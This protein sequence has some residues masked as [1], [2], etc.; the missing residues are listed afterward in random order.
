MDAFW[1]FISVFGWPLALVLLLLSF[2]ASFATKSTFKK[3]GAVANSRGFTGA[4]VAERILGSHQLSGKFGAGY[5]VKV[6]RASGM[7]TDHYSPREKVLRLSDGV[8][9]TASIAAAGVAAHECGHALQDADGF[10]PNK[11]RSAIAPVAGIG[12]KAGPYIAIA[13]VFLLY[14]MPNTPFGTILI[15]IGII[16]YFIAFVFYIVTLPV[17]FDASRRAIAVLREEGI[18]TENELDGARK[19]LR[20]AAMTYVVAALSSLLM[21][22][23]LMSMGRRRRS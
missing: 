4:E 7:L 9:A 18:L 14:Q 3:Y 16:A 19:V 8:Y 6:E 11:I 22:L 21:L 13:G 23:R 12:S 15:N 10:I 2:I 5:A 17:E 20:A 1:D